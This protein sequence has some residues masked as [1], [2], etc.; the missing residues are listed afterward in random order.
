[1]FSL[2]VD[3]GVLI[4][5]ILFV[6]FVLRIYSVIGTMILIMMM[7]MMM[8]VF[9]FTINLERIGGYLVLRLGDRSAP[10]K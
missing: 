10:K 7:M 9:F 6:G 3:C 8:I 2:Y 1:V 4:Y 5:S